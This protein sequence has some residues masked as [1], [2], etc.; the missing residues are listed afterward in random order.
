MISRKQRVDLYKHVARVLKESGEVA[1]E[2]F[3]LR[4]SEITVDAT[5]E[6]LE[7]C[8]C[9]YPDKCFCTPLQKALRDA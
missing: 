2:G 1:G 9:V 7:P 3:I 5:L 8:R 6:A 4:L